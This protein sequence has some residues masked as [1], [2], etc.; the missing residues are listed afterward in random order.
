MENKIKIFVVDDDLFTLNIYRQGLENMGYENI[1]LF[2]NGTVCLNNLNKKPKVIFLDHDMNDL[3]G[4]EVLKKIKRY[5]PD[6]YVVLV[7]AQE[8]MTVA[9]EALKYGAFDYIIKGN[10]DLDKMQKAL[11]RIEGIEREINKEEPSLI[12]KIMPFI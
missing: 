8:K 1:T 12:K 3:T 4:F 5:N 9:I 11:F 10:D 7:S 2:L 6:I